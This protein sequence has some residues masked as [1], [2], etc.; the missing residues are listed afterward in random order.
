MSFS[1]AMLNEKLDGYI[2]TGIYSREHSYVYT[3]EIKQ[4]KPQR[5]LSKEEVEALNR[6]LKKSGI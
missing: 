1:V 6:A 5:E 4:G 2:L 3:K